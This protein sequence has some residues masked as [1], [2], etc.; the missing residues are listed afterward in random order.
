MWIPIC[1][2]YAGGALS[3]SR[4]CTLKSFGEEAWG[5]Q[6]NIA[7]V[8]LRVSKPLLRSKSFESLSSW[9]PWI[10]AI[11]GLSDW[12]RSARETRVRGIDTSA[13]YQRRLGPEVV[14]A[15]LQAHLD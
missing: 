5:P 4:L 2:L 7:I 10:S 12:I 9:Y 6:R 1:K 15:V 8:P 14:L 11:A 13:T 3:N